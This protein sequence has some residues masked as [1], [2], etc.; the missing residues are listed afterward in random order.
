[1]PIGYLDVPAGAGH[2]TKKQLV[3]AIYDAL[4]DV[5]P[6]PDDTRI[7]LREWSLDSASRN[8]LL[9]A[10][11]VR[12]VLTLHIPQGGNVDAK[13]KMLKKVNNA[14]ASAY[15]RP[16]FMVFMQEYPLDLVAHEGG[17]LADNQQRVEDQKNAYS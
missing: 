3:K 14:V 11:P 10:E 17:L 6:F 9:G 7:F 8:G 5:W 1:M 15:Q 16:D 12:P 2:D 13:R 4:H